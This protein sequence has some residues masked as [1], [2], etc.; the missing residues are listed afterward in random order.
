M[1]LRQHIK[2]QGIA[3]RTRV[4]RQRGKGPKKYQ[5][6]EGSARFQIFFIRS[7]GR[8]L[9]ISTMMTLNRLVADY[10]TGV[11]PG[12]AVALSPYCCRVHSR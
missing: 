9:L 10:I 12:D 8:F 1:K 3:L 11:G 7:P 6:E 5:Y 2:G 4:K